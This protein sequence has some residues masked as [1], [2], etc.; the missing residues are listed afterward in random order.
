MTKREFWT[1]MDNCRDGNCEVYFA[2]LEDT[3][4]TLPAAEL[5]QFRAYL[6]AYLEAATDCVW[7]DMA[8]KVINGYVS[9]DTALYFA[10]WVVSQG[11][12]PL[13]QALTDPDSLAEL[14]GIPFENADFEFLMSVGAPEEDE[15]DA[16]DWDEDFDVPGDI[17]MLAAG[18]DNAVRKACC[19]EIQGEV[20]YKN[21]DR[22]GG[23][24]S[25]EAAMED[26]PNI[27]PRL[28]RRA[29]EAGFSWQS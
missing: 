10:L 13:L 22:F 7:L 28:I 14:H 6:A 20:R 1:I 8:C 24:D 25:F 2:S 15:G 19:L 4:A 23:Y 9:D 21:G 26:I 29:E 12:G 27:L 3:V 17:G 18:I 5:E 16:E 11:E